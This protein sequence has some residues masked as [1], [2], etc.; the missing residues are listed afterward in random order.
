MPGQPADMKK[1]P[2]LRGRRPL[3]GLDWGS[4]E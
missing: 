1:R 2:A 4:V 3:K